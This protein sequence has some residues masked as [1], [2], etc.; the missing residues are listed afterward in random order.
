VRRVDRRT[1]TALARSPAVA[2]LFGGADDKSTAGKDSR[3]DVPIVEETLDA[4]ANRAMLALVLALMRRARSLRER[5]QELVEREPISET[6][7]SLSA[8][9]PARRQVLEDLT[10]R[11]KVLY[12]SPRAR[13]WWA[14]GPGENR[15]PLK[16]RAF[17][18]NVPD[19][20]HH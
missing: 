18:G 2:V 7:T 4:A 20:R 5:L 17:H 11:L 6:R 3:L 8:R 1:A 13:I 12:R 15:P 14:V 10:V 9:W 19:S 16:P